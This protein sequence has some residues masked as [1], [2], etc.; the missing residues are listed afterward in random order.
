MELRALGIGLHGA[1]R[2]ARRSSHRVRWSRPCVL[3]LF[4][5]STSTVN[6]HLK[7]IFRQDELEEDSVI[8]NFR[9]TAADGK[10]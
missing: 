3:R 6:E 8:R 5:V 7:N 1:K 4:D 10:V 9:I 2:M